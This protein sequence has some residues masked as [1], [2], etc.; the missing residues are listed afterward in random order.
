MLYTELTVFKMYRG[1]C[2]GNK[3]MKIIDMNE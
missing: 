2:I 3:I 1:T